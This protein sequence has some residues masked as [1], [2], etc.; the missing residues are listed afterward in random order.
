MAVMKKP[1]NKKLKGK[2]KAKGGHPHII[3]HY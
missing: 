2:T 3:K 1:K